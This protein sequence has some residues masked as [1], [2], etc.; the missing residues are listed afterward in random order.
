MPAWLPWAAWAVTTLALILEIA[1]GMDL[2]RDIRRLE[3]LLGIRP[4]D[5]PVR[6]QRAAVWINKNKPWNRKPSPRKENELFEALL[7]IDKLFDLSRLQEEKATK[8][9]AGVEPD[10]PW[11]RK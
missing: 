2:R 5:E 3:R 10:A 11:P 4:E 7:M 8:D 6:H 1:S 9:K